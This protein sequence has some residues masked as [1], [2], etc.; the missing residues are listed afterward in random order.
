MIRLDQSIFFKRLN[1]ASGRNEIKPNKNGR[2][3]MFIIVESV[4]HKYYTEISFLLSLHCI[5]ARKF[6]NL[7]LSCVLLESTLHMKL[8]RNSSG[9]RQ[10]KSEEG[11]L[12]L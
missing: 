1:I 2:T 10:I 12:H 4:S 8:N 7:S 11:P 5:V 6:C 3:M 9:P